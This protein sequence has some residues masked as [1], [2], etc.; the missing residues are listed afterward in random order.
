MNER[1]WFKVRIHVIRIGSGAGGRGGAEPRGVRPDGPHGPRRPQKRSP[2]S[3]LEPLLGLRGPRAPRAPP[4]EIRSGRGRWEH[5][6]GALEA[7]KQALR[8]HDPDPPPNTH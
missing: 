5:K 6:K 1:S 7:S 8:G 2:E 4:D 3:D